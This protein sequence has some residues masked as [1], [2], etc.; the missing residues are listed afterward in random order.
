[1]FKTF[2]SVSA[3]W[4]VTKFVKRKFVGFVELGVYSKR[5]D[6]KNSNLGITVTD[7]GRFWQV[8][9]VT[10]NDCQGGK[11]RARL[12]FLLFASK[13]GRKTDRFLAFH[14]QV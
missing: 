8:Y 1:M 4:I 12:D 2:S 3:I 11:F 5:W 6:V 13:K 9:R 14:A 7:R 10:G